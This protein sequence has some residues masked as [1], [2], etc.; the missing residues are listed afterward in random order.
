MSVLEHISPEIM[1]DY[2]DKALITAQTVFECATTTQNLILV[3]HG[4]YS[5]HRN[6]FQMCETNNIK[7]LG[8]Y[9]CNE[10]QNIN[11]N[12]PSNISLILDGLESNTI[13]IHNKIN[14]IMIR[15]CK[16]INLIIP[17]ST[18]SGID[19]LYCNKIHLITP[20]INS[21][22][23]EYDENIYFEGTIDSDSNINITG[24]LDIKINNE[25]LP[26]NPFISAVYNNNNWIINKKHILPKLTIIK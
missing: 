13:L 16:N 22:N 1:S 11:L 4:P 9:Y 2:Q 17:Q 15:K 8:E 12:L 14:H 24:C 25:S 6:K 5:I 20:I 3:I 19:V 23:L 10:N 26:I 21:I 7:T 18:I